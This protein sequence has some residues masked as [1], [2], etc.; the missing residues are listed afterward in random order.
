MNKNSNLDMGAAVARANRCLRIARLLAFRS[1]LVPVIA[2]LGSIVAIS[3]A[4]FMRSGSFS[5]ETNSTMDWTIAGLILL[6]SYS[7]IRLIAGEFTSRLSVQVKRSEMLDLNAAARVRAEESVD[8]VGGD[9]SWLE[10]DLP[11]L[12]A[13]RIEKP[14]VLARIF[15]DRTRLSP[16]RFEQIA[17][18]YL[19]DIQPVPYPIGVSSPFKG[20]VVDREDPEARKLY[21]YTRQ[22]TAPVGKPRAFDRFRWEEFGPESSPLIDS[23]SSFLAAACTMRDSPVRI[24][25][26]GANNVGKTS[27]A[28]A[29]KNALG[30]PLEVC[31]FVDAFRTTGSGIGLEDNL[32]ALITQVLDSQSVDCDVAIYD[33]TFVDTLCFL[34]LKT[35]DRER[36]YNLLAPKIASAM[37]RF[38]FV[39]DVK[40]QADDYTSSTKLVPGS[41]RKFVRDR[42]DEFFST[43]GIATREVIIDDAKFDESIVEH[44]RQLAVE[45]NSILKHR[46]MVGP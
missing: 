9:L 20:M 8:I 40:R 35:H 33:R 29:L 5:F 36:I 31:V 28:N 23:V 4:W 13:F 17:R 30:E 46:R 2:H 10:E 25:I 19:I 39:I 38:S 24:G 14:G 21:V 37:E 42:L 44:A 27:L 22:T 45:I 18:L 34:C 15:Y 1:I 3:A 32:L 43:Y 7:G 26:S 11:A 6:I 16:S 41:D 12:E